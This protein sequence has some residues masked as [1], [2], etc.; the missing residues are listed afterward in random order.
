MTARQ[1]VL[2]TGGRYPGAAEIARAEIV[3]DAGA[4]EPLPSGTRSIEARELLPAAAAEALSAACREFAVSWHRGLRASPRLDLPPGRAIETVVTIELALALKHLILLRKLAL[5]EGCLRVTADATR[6]P[7]ARI[8]PVLAA[9]PVPVE[10]RGRPLSLALLRRAASWTRAAWARPRPPRGATGPARAEGLSGAIP[11]DKR[12]RVWGLANYRNRPLL[13]ALSHDRRFSV[14]LIE[15]SAENHYLPSEH[16]RRDDDPALAQETRRIARE[17]R[18]L[19]RERTR[20]L[21]AGLPGADLVAQS[22]VEEALARLVPACEAEARGWRQA[23]ED[24]PPDLILAGIPWGGDLRSLALVCASGPPLV[25]C[26]DGVLAEVGAGGV[27]V[28]GGALAWGPRGRDWFASRG[29]PGHAIFEVGDPY[30]DRLV[31]DV[32]RASGSLRGRLGVPADEK[33]LL[34]SVQN[35]A[36]HFLPGDP[37]DP[38]RFARMLAEAL[39]HVT[40]WCLV[41][42]PHPR[43]PLVDGAERLR[44]LQRIAGESP[45]ARL[46]DPAE[47]IA[48][49]I[50]LADAHVSEGDTLSLEM[51]ACGKASILF[52]REDLFAPYPE[53]ASTGAMPVVHSPQELAGTLGRGVSP[54]LETARRALLD[55]HLSARISPAEALVSLIE[56]GSRQR[57]METQ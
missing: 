53:F 10:I 17:S 7:I 3:L 56:Q 25:A 41:L 15:R 5:R 31:E 22:I 54:P 38:V 9:D 19:V 55:S 23:L 21:F 11:G 28:A 6:P 45:S 39:T 4:A 40:G 27:P 50:A 8:A 16:R 18:D 57:R 52:Q 30:L 24:D 43:L 14:R 48:G 26:Q 46:A 20:A 12:I 51:L 47:P 29:V 13:E 37:A 33:V 42:K 44:L 2:L 35:S 34:A 49:L 1:V 36:P 32:G